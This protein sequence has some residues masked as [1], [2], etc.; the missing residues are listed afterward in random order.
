MESDKSERIPPKRKVRKIRYN[1]KFYFVRNTI[2]VILLSLLVFYFIKSDFFD[3]KRVVVIGNVLLSEEY[4]LENANVP[5][6]SNI[7][8]IDKRLIEENLEVL[9]MIRE[10]RVER[11]LPSTLYIHIKER[12]HGAVVAVYG[13]FIL[14]DIEG[15][16][17]QNV[18]FIGEF[19]DLPLITGLF[20]EENL[21]YG[22][23]I[24]SKALRAA[25]EM[26]GQI[27]EEHNAYFIEVDIS[28][29]ENDIVLFTNE[30]IMVKVGSMEDIHE[31]LAIF[32]KIHSEHVE[33][34]TLYRLKYINISIAGL[35]V[36]K[37]K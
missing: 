30:G 3:C 7:F 5:I 4:I 22:Q 9:T 21:I 32:R 2:I 13:K 19:L 20:L 10:V 1:R 35:P 17:M 14:V 18:E 6:G 36:I 16:Y 11:R 27:W 29:G 23:Q 26:S 37:Y 25:I 33:E 34:G 24:D 12:E 15:I 28:A 31:K 8:Y